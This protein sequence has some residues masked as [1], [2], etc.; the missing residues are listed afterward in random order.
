MF[1]Q[2][3][4]AG[5]A[6]LE[7]FVPKISASAQV[8]PNTCWSQCWQCNRAYGYGKVDQ[9]CSYNA[10]CCSTGGGYYKCYC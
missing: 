9:W 7:R 8:S 6:L 1:R 3:E 10:E 4:S 5:Q 2:L